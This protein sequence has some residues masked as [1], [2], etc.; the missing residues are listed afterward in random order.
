V[1]QQI[2]DLAKS[3]N[4]SLEEAKR[5]TLARQPTNRFVTVEEV[6]ALAAFLAG[7][8]AAS[9]TGANYC[10]DGGWTAQ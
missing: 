5:Q 2:P 3:E 4:I 10:I 7:D 1:E 9:I 8:A 6:A